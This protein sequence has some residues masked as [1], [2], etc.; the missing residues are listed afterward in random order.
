M[1][2]NTKKLKREM[3]LAGDSASDLAKKINRTTRAVHKALK[4]E[5]TKLVTIDLIAE[6]Y[7]ID[8]KDLLI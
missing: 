6:V 1:K 8:A 2:L 5:T 3:E 4:N 7:G